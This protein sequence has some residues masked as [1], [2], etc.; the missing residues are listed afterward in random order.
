MPNPYEVVQGDTGEVIGGTLLDGGQPFPI[1]P[2]AD[3][4]F[5]MMPATR[6]QAGPNFMKAAEDR[7]AQEGTGRWR[8]RFTD[9]TDTA[10]PGPYKAKVRVMTAE[11]WLSFPKDE[12]LDVIVTP[13]PGGG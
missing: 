10:V 8:Y 1:P 5:G 12:Y 9:P 3:V 7:T 4:E 13:V 2:G 6:G 11:G